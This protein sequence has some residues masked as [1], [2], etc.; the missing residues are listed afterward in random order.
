M[1]S[2][3]YVRSPTNF[4]SSFVCAIFINFYS[5]ASLMLTGLAFVDT[6]HGDKNFKGRE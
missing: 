5:L 6:G 1:E 4:L 2:L 3:M